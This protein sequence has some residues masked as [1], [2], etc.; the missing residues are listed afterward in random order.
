MFSVATT[1]MLVSMT[2]VVV[3]VVV[4]IVIVVMIVVV[5]VMRYNVDIPRVVSSRQTT[6]N[7]TKARIKQRRWDG[8]NRRKLYRFGLFK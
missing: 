4:V 2:V 5:F 1:S 8:W 7:R 3:V 6:F